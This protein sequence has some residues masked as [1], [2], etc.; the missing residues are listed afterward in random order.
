MVKGGGRWPRRASIRLTRDGFSQPLGLRRT[1]NRRFASLSPCSHCT[2]RCHHM[3]CPDSRTQTVLVAA[4]AFTSERHMEYSRSLSP[5]LRRCQRPSRLTCRG[6]PQASTNSSGT[7]IAYFYVT[8]Q[9]VVR[10]LNVGQEAIESLVIEAQKFHGVQ[11]DISLQ[12]V[13][14]RETVT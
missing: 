10:I 14:S 3:W 11:N 8:S 4:V 13:P 9:H 2:K 5:P 7:A 6:R 1:E 12:D